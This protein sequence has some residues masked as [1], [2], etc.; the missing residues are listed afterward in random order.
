MVVSYFMAKK[1]K[2]PREE[3]RFEL[4]PVWQAFKGSVFALAMPMIIIGSILSGFVSPTEAGAIAVV[5]GLIV[6]AFVYRELTWKDCVEAMKEM[7]RTCGKI[8]ILIGSAALF[9]KL[10]TTAGFHLIVKNLLLSISTDP[11]VIMVIIAAIILVVTTFMESIATLTLLM[12][13]LYPSPRR[14]A[15]TRSCSACWWWCASA[16]GW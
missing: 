7:V 6:G 13:V 4:K 12:P 8:F 1:E 10:L 3:G 15:S 14:W 9:T 16:W 2:V 11:A 5:Y